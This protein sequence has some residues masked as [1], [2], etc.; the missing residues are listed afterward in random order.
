MSANWT[1]TLAMAVISAGCC[2][3]VDA[4]AQSLDVFRTSAQI[5][6]GPAS[7]SL[8]GNAVPICSADP[9]STELTLDLAV[10]RALCHNP[11][12]QSAWASVKVKAAGVGAAK[13]AY[14]PSI[15]ASWQGVQD[16]KVT[17]VRDYPRLSSAY[18]STVQY[19][20]LS[21]SWLLFDFGARGAQQSQAEFMFDAA[22]ANQDATLLDVFT[23]TVTDYYAAQASVAK[24]RAA[25]ESLA[26]AN[27]SL[28]VA[29]VRVSKGVAPISDQL[30]AK[31]AY[32]Q[33]RLSKEKSDGEMAAMIGALAVDMGVRP[34]TD[35]S[36]PAVDEIIL[37]SNAKHEK[38]SDLVESGIQSHP[39]IASARA[40]LEASRERVRQASAEGLPR[41]SLVANYSRN[42]Q[43]ATLGLGEPQFP[44][45]GRDWYFGIQVQIPLF[46]GF[47]R[48]YKVR[49]AQ[50]QVELQAAELAAVTQKVALSVW[51]SY[52]TLVTRQQNLLTSEQLLDAAE[53]SFTAAKRRYVVGAGG[54][55]ELL[56]TQTSLEAARLQRVQAITDWRAAK[57]QLLA[58]LGRIEAARAL[59]RGGL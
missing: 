17:E 50:A 51:K 45:T 28:Q 10:D 58:N 19:G 9:P 52:Q 42:N 23:A 43:P 34:D 35:I 53:S 4:T 27:E 15:N 32:L 38:V 1:L 29:E 3:M 21:L 31:T 59:A 55:T 41:I 54:I 39:S 14:L 18:K 25:G 11:K 37:A 20:A 12:T 5:P 36:I 6:A 40:Q 8:G 47:G 56:N 22:L 46:E 24:V 7:F 57:L 2:A 33:A 49:E 44:A 16:D 13:A 48:A 26:L 30:Q